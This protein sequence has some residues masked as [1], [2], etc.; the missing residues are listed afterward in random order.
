[1]EILHFLEKIGLS[2]NESKAYLAL[3]KNSELKVGDIIKETQIPQSKIYAILE[4]LLE[5]N[6]ISYKLKG[7]IKYFS[8][9]STK[10]LFSLLEEK[11]ERILEEK[12]LLEKNLPY[13][14]ILNEEEKT[15][16]ELFEG[17]NGLRTAYKILLE[18]TSSSSILKYYYPYSNFNSQLDNFLK[19][20]WVE[21]NGPEYSTKGILHSDIK[22]TAKF[23][24]MGESPDFKF[25]K[26]P[27]PGLIDI[28]DGK[29]LIISWEENPSAILI[30][31]K[32]ITKSFE[33]YFD[34]IW[35]ISMN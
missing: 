7:N 11:E 32:K 22:K 21:Y 8:A 31:S 25:A 26:F 14:N 24:K 1:M 2:L 6:L 29:T 17:L 4:R 20:I 30:N 35:N 13:L 34:S 19:T 12:Q 18:N 5:K 10:N 33:N 16:V 27:L 23:K 9:N 3:L 15:T 28:I